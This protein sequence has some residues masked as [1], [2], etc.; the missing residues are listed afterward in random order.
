[1]GGGGEGGEGGPQRRGNSLSKDP[2]CERPPPSAAILRAWGLAAWP[3]CGPSCRCRSSVYTPSRCRPDCVGNEPACSFLIENEQLER[4]P[5]CYTCQKCL[6]SNERSMIERRRISSQPSTNGDQTGRNARGQFVKGCP[7][8][9]GN[10]HA[11]LVGKNRARLYEVIRAADIDLA[12]KT[13]R[14]VMRNGKDSDRLAAA[15]LLFDRSLGPI[16]AVDFEERLAELER[17]A[18]E[19]QK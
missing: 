13:M 5:T 3:A 17:L 2:V 12:V 10:P 9:P 19:L 11:A 7:G 18:G 15:R 1:M 16:V 14:D 6:T 4:P 8:G